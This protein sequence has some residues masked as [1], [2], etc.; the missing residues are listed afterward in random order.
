MTLTSVSTNTTS[1]TT[2]TSGMSEPSG[3]LSESELDEL[4]GLNLS[5]QVSSLLQVRK[6]RVGCVV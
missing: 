2:S 3:V 6:G 1:H 4:E 5:E